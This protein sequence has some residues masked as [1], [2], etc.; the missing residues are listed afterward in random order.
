[1]QVIYS[2]KGKAREYADL[3]LNIYKGCTHACGYCYCGRF[4]WNKDFFKSA[5]PKKDFI[6][7]LIKDCEGL[8]KAADNIPE[9]LIS[10]FGDPYQ[11]A[12][13]ELGLTGQAV[14]VLI[15]FD[16]PFT[17]LTKGGTRAVRDFGL[18]RGYPK[19]SFGTSLSFFCDDANAE[20]WEPGAASVEDRIDALE[21]AHYYDIPTWVSLEPVIIPEHALELIRRL[22][23]V[24]DFWKVGKLN[25]FPEV[26]KLVDWKKFRNDVVELLEFYEADYYIK[27]SLRC[28]L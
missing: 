2:P 18:L 21:W 10:F 24:V 1:M 12:E 4:P 3:A 27:D 25:H 19:A 8:K 20:E 9:I 5:N 7:K 16:L 11:P 14:E 22:H 15:D 17:I 6:N 13:L 28:V 26:E 23:P